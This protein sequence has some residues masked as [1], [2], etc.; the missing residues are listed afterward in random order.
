[1]I[2][3][4]FLSFINKRSGW[5]YRAI[6]FV[7]NSYVRLLLSGRCFHIYVYIRLLFTD[8]CATYC[9]VHLFIYVYIRLLFTDFCATYCCVHLF[10]CG[11][12]YYALFWVVLTTAGLPLGMLA[13]KG[14]KKSSV[15]R[16]GTY[17]DWSDRRTQLIRYCCNNVR[18]FFKD[19]SNEDH[20][21]LLGKCC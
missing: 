14:E 15:S 13:H 18:N 21:G 16:R 12:K 5:P 9:C 20:G 11:D 19:C 17:Q 10:P 6:S 2:L 4:T 7:V 8:F 1:M 3:Q